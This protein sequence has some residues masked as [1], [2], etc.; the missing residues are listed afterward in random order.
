MKHQLSLLLIA[1]LSFAAPVGCSY[2]VI[3][4]SD[5]DTVPDIEDVCPDDPGISKD[6]GECGCG[7]RK[8]KDK[9]VY[10]GVLKD[11]DGD[12]M[13]D[14]YDLCPHDPGKT[15]PGICGCGN[16]ELDTDNDGTPDCVD[17]CR[18]DPAKTEPGFCGCGN[19][20]TDDDDGDGTP[21]CVDECKDD[22]NKTEPGFCGCGEDETDTDKDGTPDCKDTC[23]DDAY[24][25][26]PGL[27]GCGIPDT[28]S[29][30]NLKLN[31]DDLCPKDPNKTEPG[32]C[33]CGNPDNDLNHNG[34]VDC[35]EKC[36]SS[37]IGKE[38]HGICGCDKED[39]TTDSDNDSTPDCIDVCPNDPKKT[40][41]NICGCGT[42]DIDSDS[43]TIPDCIDTC[44]YDG[45]RPKSDDV[46]DCN[47]TGKTQNIDGKRV[48]VEEGGVLQAGGIEGNY[49]NTHAAMIYAF[50]NRTVSSTTITLTYAP[51]GNLLYN[52]A[53]EYDDNGW[54]ITSYE[55]HYTGCFGD[56]D[57]RPFGNY[58][59]LRS[60][61]DGSTFSQK[62]DFTNIKEYLKDIT[63]TESSENPSDI[64]CMQNLTLAVFAISQCE[65]KSDASPCYTQCD[66]KQ[67]SIQ[68]E[69]CLSEN[70]D[71][72]TSSKLGL[73]NKHIHT[74]YSSPYKLFTYSKEINL[75]TLSDPDS[76]IKASFK[77]FDGR[78]WTGYYGAGLQ[79]F[80]A[81]LGER[82]I[83]FSNDGEN[84]KEPWEKF[85][86][87]PNGFSDA[88]YEINWD[89]TKY[90]GNAEPG[91]KTVY[92]QTHDLLTDK[93]YETSS[94]FT[95]SP[96]S[97]G[98]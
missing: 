97:S 43:D 20:D 30:G 78:L 3:V 26:E 72:Y 90:G 29:E 24:K 93:Y 22:P 92:M 70:Q 31:C 58:P 4:D 74:N 83:R 59:C 69:L 60:S 46:C 79:Y 33:G 17:E 45:T 27:C 84:W 13:P 87:S 11:D 2:E 25:T 75:K 56:N 82:E 36:L 80:A 55:R 62:I 88:W 34:I 16:A 65:C 9:C 8:I 7:Y 50:H 15:E 96:T 53:L 66:K 14:L 77:G 61:Y 85:S 40:Q 44:P 32:F 47:S 71:A 35:L 49:P 67:D 57:M 68:I 19:T 48:C 94:T 86:P 5:G 63:C 41:T 28:D 89:L 6:E 1:L 91:Q 81:Y 95:Y 37:S 54:E 39:D 51:A 98:E 64:A 42:P 18:E 21:N 52:P 38:T 12:G 73:D 76:F 10:M 23:P